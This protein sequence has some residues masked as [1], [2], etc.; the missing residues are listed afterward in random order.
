MSVKLLTEY[1]L[2]FRSLKGGCACSPESTLVKMSHCWK[3]RV[4]AQLF[5]LRLNLFHT[6]HVQAAHDLVIL[7]GFY[8]LV[9]PFSWLLHQVSYVLAHWNICV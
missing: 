3:S 8:G 1:H 2:E 7:C 5:S 9:Q 6:L 4:T